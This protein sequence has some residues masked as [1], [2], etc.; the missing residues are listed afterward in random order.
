MDGHQKKVVSM[1]RG[2]IFEKRISISAECNTVTS[3]T[4]W[5]KLDESEQDNIRQ[6]QQQLKSIPNVKGNLCNT[7]VIS[8]RILLLFNIV[9]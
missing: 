3:W 2:E 9:T 7:K 4:L 8:L 1:V 5:N 6:Y